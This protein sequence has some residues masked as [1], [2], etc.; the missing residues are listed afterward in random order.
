MV[1]KLYRYRL[2]ECCE[3]PSVAGRENYRSRS[4]RAQELEFHGID[5]KLV[6]SAMGNDLTSTADSL[7]AGNPTE[8]A[9]QGIAPKG[10]Y[11]ICDI[12]DK[13][14]LETDKSIKFS[15]SDADDNAYLDAVKRGDMETALSRSA[16][17]TETGSDKSDTSDTSNAI[18]SC[19]KLEG[20][21]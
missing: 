4:Y 13:I 3:S 9:K 6:V 21:F 1:V 16:R 2:S 15:I 8:A 19:D 20:V 7:L 5:R 10:L 11:T 18:H 12:F 14:K 17:A